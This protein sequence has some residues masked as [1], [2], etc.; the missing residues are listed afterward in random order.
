MTSRKTGIFV[1]TIILLWLSRNHHVQLLSVRVGEFCHPARSRYNMRIVYGFLY[2]TRLLVMFFAGD[3]CF[4]PVYYVVSPGNMIRY[5]V[6]TPIASAII[7]AAM[8]IWARFLRLFTTSAMENSI[9]RWISRVEKCSTLS[10]IAGA[11]IALI[12]CSVIKVG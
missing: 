6:Y 8:V 10:D 1:C 2:F 9:A 5:W 7:A 4:L 11:M 3:L 12:G